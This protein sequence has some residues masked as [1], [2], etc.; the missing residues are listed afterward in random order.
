MQSLEKGLDEVRALFER[1]TGA[2]APEVDPRFFL[3]F[4][5]GVDPVAFALDEVSRIKKAL[6]DSQPART[7]TRPAWVPAANVFA[8]ENQIRFTLDVPGV[9]KEDISVTVNGQ[10]LVIRGERRAGNF[11]GTVQPMVVER[12]WG[13]FERRFPLPPWCDPGKVR[14]RYENGT[15]EIGVTRFDE[16]GSGNF[17]VRIA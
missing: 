17:A 5:P 6:D 1:V 14:A 7:Q 12:P 15:L 3:P 4:P 9:A 8:G 13:A 11:N 16:G 10:E 2:P